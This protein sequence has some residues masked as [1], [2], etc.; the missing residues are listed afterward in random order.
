M[1]ML[2]VGPKTNII[3]NISWGVIRSFSLF[4][5]SPQSTNVFDRG[6]EYGAAICGQ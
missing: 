4:C 3:I 6:A 2:I 1:N 5:G